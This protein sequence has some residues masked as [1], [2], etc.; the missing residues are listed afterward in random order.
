MRTRPNQTGENQTEP[1]G[2][3]IQTEPDGVRTELNQITAHLVATKK[4]I[5]LDAVRAKARHPNNNVS[6]RLVVRDDEKEK[7]DNI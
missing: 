6:N 3:E 7:V 5:R 4:M 1:D 2:G